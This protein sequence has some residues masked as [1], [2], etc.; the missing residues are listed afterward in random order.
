MAD[1][2]RTHFLEPV[3]DVQQRLVHKVEDL[4]GFIVKRAWHAGQQLVHGFEAAGSTV[5]HKAT[6]PIVGAVTALDKGVHERVKR[7]EGAA[8]TVLHNVEN[9]GTHVIHSLEHAT[10]RLARNIN[11]GIVHPAIHAVEQPIANAWHEVEHLASNA[12]HGVEHVAGDVAHAAARP[13]RIMLYGGML[14]GG[15]WFWRVLE[16]QREEQLIKRRRYR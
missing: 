13:F 6:A 2:F 1:W 12:W 15:Y 5:V 10:A 16:D 3:H 4:G 9:A 14:I 8:S 11:T 7:V